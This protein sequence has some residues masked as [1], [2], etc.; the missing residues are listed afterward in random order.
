MLLLFKPS[1]PRVRS[2]SADAISRL[3]QSANEKERFAETTDGASA[4]TDLLTA[5]V[6]EVRKSATLAIASIAESEVAAM[7][8]YKAG[9]VFY[10]L[11]DVLVHV[12]RPA[13]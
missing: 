13:C 5:P 8:L 9:L 11:P 4:L 7:A 3:L 1:S 2:K 6:D 10:V 12:Q